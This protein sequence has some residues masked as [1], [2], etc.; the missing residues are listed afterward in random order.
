MTDAAVRRGAQVYSHDGSQL[1]E[2]GETRPHHLQVVS[3]NG[4]PGIGSD[5]WLER[6]LIEDATIDRV[7]VGFV[8]DQLQ[9]YRTAEP[10]AEHVVPAT[11]KHDAYIEGATADEANELADP[12]LES[13]ALDDRARDSRSA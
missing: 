2:V 8:A 5:F 10:G 11:S 6:S 7:T 13:S 9:E 3:T 1:G 12:T 4:I